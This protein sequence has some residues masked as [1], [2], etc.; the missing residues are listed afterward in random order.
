MILDAKF[1]MKD[2]DVFIL[3]VSL[4]FFVMNGGRRYLVEIL[5]TSLHEEMIKKRMTKDVLLACFCLDAL[6]KVSFCHLI[7]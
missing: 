2:W 1:W 4:K 3:K 5:L 7:E 6:Y